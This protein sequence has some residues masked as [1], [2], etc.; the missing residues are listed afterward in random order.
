MGDLGA[1]AANWCQSKARVLRCA[2][3]AYGSVAHV[4]GN[5]YGATGVATNLVGNCCEYRCE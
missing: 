4:S 3:R 1:E 5:A 2:E